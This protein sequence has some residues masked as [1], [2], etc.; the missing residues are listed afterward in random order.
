MAAQVLQWEL[1]EEH[2]HEVLGEEG[3]R[4][5]LRRNPVRQAERQRSRAQKQP[6]LTAALRQAHTYFEQHPR[7]QVAT[8]QLDGC[9]VVETDLQPAPAAA[10]TIHDR[11]KDLALVER[12]FRTRRT[13][14]LEFRPWFVGTADN[15][16]AQALTAL[17]AL[18]V[19]RHWERAWS[20]LEVTV[21]EGLRELEQLCVLELIH[22]GS[23]QVVVC[24]VPS[25]VCASSN[26]W[27]R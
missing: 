23:G 8:Q 7:A 4:Y 17:L 19:R 12:D 1:F 5:V 16:Q 14:H 27:T 9:Y 18:K 3:R 26:R 10:L 6:S 11:Y 21:E 15:T 25:R 24:Q 2:V 22:P 20:S 13:G